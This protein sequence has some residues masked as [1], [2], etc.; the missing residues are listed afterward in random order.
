MHGRHDPVATRA[1]VLVQELAH[2]HGLADTM[3][4][5]KEF[6]A[7]RVRAMYRDSQTVLMHPCMV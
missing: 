4:R 3:G 7:D 1:K 6:Q 5:A 2:G